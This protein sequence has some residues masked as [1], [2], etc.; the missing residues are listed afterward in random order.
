MTQ[1]GGQL[2]NKLMNSQPTITAVNTSTKENKPMPTIPAK[3]TTVFTNVTN[4][5]MPFGSM[6]YFMGIKYDVKY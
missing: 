6:P 4:Q 2:Y 3:K 5:A 1:I